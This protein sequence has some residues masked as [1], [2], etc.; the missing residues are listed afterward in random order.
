MKIRKQTSM[1]LTLL[2][3][4][5]LFGA[6]F[7]DGGLSSPEFAK[8]SMTIMVSISQ[9]PL[10]TST[11]ENNLI[12]PFNDYFE[13]LAECKQ[14]SNNYTIQNVNNFKFNKR[15]LDMLNYAASLY[16]GSIDITGND[17]TQG[18][19]SGGVPLSYSTHL[20]GGAVDISVYDK[21]G[22]RWRIREEE[23]GPLLAALRVAGFAA[24]YRPPD[25]EGNYEA[26]H[27][28]AIAIGDKDLSNEALNQVVGACGYLQGYVGFP[29][30]D[31]DCNNTQ[32]PISDNYG[33][34]IVCNWMCGLGYDVLEN[35][36]R[37][38]P[39]MNGFVK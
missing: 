22:E 5:A 13:E 28:H 24:W 4:V 39:I 26:P 19:Y 25:F 20:G 18:A 2:V 37:C 7:L 34:P 23:I 14:P 10:T 17:I 16:G 30:L 31:R 21:S 38:N 29:I 27:I 36:I 3:L 1:R 8:D 11:I 15:T 12:F 9:V 32:N 6:F 35:D 33:G